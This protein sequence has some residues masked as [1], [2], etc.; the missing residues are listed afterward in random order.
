MGKL[1]SKNHNFACRFV[2]VLNFSFMLR[3]GLRILVDMVLRRIFVA[4]REEVI[5]GSRKLHNEEVCNLYSAP[6]INSRRMSWAGNVAR[7]GEKRNTYRVFFWEVQKE[8]DQ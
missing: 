4:K 1:K 7:M 6:N 2:W 8:K 3:E 5:T